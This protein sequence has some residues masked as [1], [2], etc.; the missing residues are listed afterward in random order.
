[1]MVNEKV[2]RG[3]LSG[4]DVAKIEKRATPQNPKPITF[5]LG[6]LCSGTVNGFLPGVLR[7][8]VKSYA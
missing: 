7:R 8:E 4:A 6:A 3:K 5:P 2:R 1:M